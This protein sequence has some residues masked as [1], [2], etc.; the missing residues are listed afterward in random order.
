M[1][2]N[3]SAFL[4]E[5]IISAINEKEREME[6]KSKIDLI[7]KQIEKGF[8]TINGEVM[9]FVEKR[10][11]ENRIIMYLPKDFKLMDPYIASIKYPYESRPNPIYTDETT[12]KNICFNYMDSE[13]EEDGIGELKDSMRAVLEKMQPA[14]YWLEDGLEKINGRN[15]GFFEIVIPALDAN[16]YNLMF[17]AQLNKRA[18]LCSISCPEE[19]I[20]GWKPIARGMM[21]S[22]KVLEDNER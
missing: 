1:D 11:F 17:F 6:Q 13:V 9:E 7:G 22:F 10:L 8:V 18:M 20:E 15:I 16:A 2:E 4:D 14:A 21:S 12:T 5:S 19:D 3:K